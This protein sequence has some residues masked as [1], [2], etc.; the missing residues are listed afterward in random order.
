MPPTIRIRRPIVVCAVVSACL[1][2]CVPGAQTRGSGVN[3]E[4]VIER[5]KSEVYP[6]LVSIKPIREEFTEG[7]KK[8]EQILGSGVIISK[9]GLVVTNNHVA[10][11]A[12]DIKC[13]LFDKEQVPAKTVGLDP[14]T[15]LALLRLELPEEHAPLPEASFGDSE[16]VHAGQFVMALGSPYGFTRSI[17]LGIIS[18]TKRYIGFETIYKYN[19][20]LQTD[21]AINPGNSG[22]PLVDTQGKVIGINTLGAG[23]AGLGFSIPSNIVKVVVQRILKDDR[24]IR[25]WTGLNLQP[26]KDFYS[27]TFVDAEEGVLISH[28]DRESPAEE[29]G[30]QAKDILVAVNGEKIDGTYVESLP[31]IR[32]RLADLP[33]GKESTFA[34][35]RRKG[36]GT[37]RIEI[38]LTPTEKGKFEG[39]DFDCKR[40]NMTVKEISQFRDPDLYFHK[41]K[42]VYIRG[43]RYPGN[44]SNAGLKRR[45][46][47]VMI[48]K[49][50]VESLQD[51]KKIYEGII[52][53][54]KREKKVAFE[55]LRGG[56]RVWKILDY[57]TDYSKE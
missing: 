20:W 52:A 14:E 22:G 42:G 34:I 54:E 31:G 1:A 57:R 33:I 26:L 44:A 55:L 11:K 45:D 30:V 17:S 13:V 5:A 12:V 24:V 41:K 35:D 43:I 4:E 46:I 25:A 9:D 29:A 53:D 36:A 48:D 6:C 19:T 7:E 23:G 27:D 56:Y 38:K 40:W 21:A 47:I 18:N 32:W 50:K 2:G 8:R 16:N 15:D 37:E 39:K 49:K 28:V 3:F 10:K 51:V